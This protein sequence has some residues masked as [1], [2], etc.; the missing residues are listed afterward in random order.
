MRKISVFLLILV[1]SLT[2]VSAANLPQPTDKY[3]NDFAGVFSSDKIINL[4][5]L[6]SGLEQDT[7]AE[8][9]VVT[10]NEC[11]SFGGPSQFAIDLSNNWGVGKSDKNNGLLLL[12]CRTE[13]KVWVSV[14]YGLEG[15]LPDSKIGSLLDDN[16]VPLRDLGNVSD[17]ILEFSK[18]AAQVIEDNKA[19]VISGQTSGTSQTEGVAI[20]I[21]V[22]IIIFL[23]GIGL[24]F[25][26]KRKTKRGF[27]D[28]WT[29]FFIDFIVRMI[30]YSILLRGGNRNSGTGGFGGG[31][32][33]GGF[34]G[35]SFGGGGAG[36]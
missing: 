1:V 14:G 17:G 36:R 24:Y 2:L 33:G 3:V 8:F 10:Y 32:G 15:I 22:I 27:G 20:V 12:Y 11:A 35:G 4:R 25:A 16:Y 5:T 31:F 6:F 28:F 7:T 26:V 30:I 29:F 9:V 13:N 21:T 19:E 18:A 23:V 34:G